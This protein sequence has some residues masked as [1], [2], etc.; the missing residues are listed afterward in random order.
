MD[1]EV[2]APH[3]Q[4]LSVPLFK[5]LKFQKDW[6]P[7]L[8]APEGSAPILLRFQWGWWWGELSSSLWLPTLKLYQ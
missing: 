7:I 3:L 1:E 2:R 5:K 8:L 4:Q 6:S